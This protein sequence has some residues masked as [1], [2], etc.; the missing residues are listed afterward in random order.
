MLK[1]TIKFLKVIFVLVILLSIYTE[2]LGKQAKAENDFNVDILPQ[3][4]DSANQ[5]PEDTFR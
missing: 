5:P 1:N 2:S 3:Y 4:K